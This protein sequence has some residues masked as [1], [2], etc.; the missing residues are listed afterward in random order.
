MY[1][2]IHGAPSHYRFDLDHRCT[3]LSFSC[4]A[5]SNFATSGLLIA[6]A[7]AFVLWRLY[8]LLGRYQARARNESREL[9]PTASVLW[10]IDQSARRRGHHHPRHAHQRGG[11]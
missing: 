11:A 3:N 4:G 7:S 10:F 8:L 5:L 1:I 9:V 2:L 6:I